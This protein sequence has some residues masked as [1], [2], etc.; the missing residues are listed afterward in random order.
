M[1]YLNEKYTINIVSVNLARNISNNNNHSCVSTIFI[2]NDIIKENKNEE[3]E[4]NINSKSI[5][6]NNINF[7]NNSND[8]LLLEFFIDIW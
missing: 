7:Y 6:L 4:I 2:N 8:Q 5:L 1:I 3:T